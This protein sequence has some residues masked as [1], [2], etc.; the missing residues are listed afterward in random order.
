MLSNF[1]HICVND[2]FHPYI[3]VNDQFQIHLKLVLIHV[4]VVICTYAVRFIHA[5]YNL[6]N[7]FYHT[8]IQHMTWFMSS[9]SIPISQCIILGSIIHETMFKLFGKCHCWDHLFVHPFSWIGFFDTLSSFFFLP[10]PQF[11]GLLFLSALSSPFFPSALS[12]FCPLFFPVLG[13]SHLFCENRTTPLLT[14]GYENLIGPLIYI[15]G[16]VSTNQFLRIF[17]FSKFT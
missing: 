11:L 6:S 5:N 12:H 13:G 1:I 3:C 8:F 7:K 14:L 10:T 17:I 9:H 16:L 2:Q 15:F 4:H